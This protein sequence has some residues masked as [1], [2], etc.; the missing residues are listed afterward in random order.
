MKWLFSVVRI[1]L[2]R[3]K[4]IPDF[5]VLIKGIEPF[6]GI[7]NFFLPVPLKSNLRIFA[8][9]SKHQHS[10]ETE[11]K[12]QVHGMSGSFAL[13]ANCIKSH[14]VCHYFFISLG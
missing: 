13:D 10:I 5:S 8:E 14:I 6:W 1:L 11:T 3:N 4:I 9:S 7:L 2:K 12:N